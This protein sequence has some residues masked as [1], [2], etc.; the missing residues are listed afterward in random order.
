MR[1]IGKA[2]EFDV[3]L[4][5]R[6]YKTLEHPSTAKTML[7]IQYRFTAELG[8]FPSQEFYEGRL[9]SGLTDSRRIL[10]RLSEQTT[11]PWPTNSD[12]GI[13]IPTVFVNC[14]S[15]EDM[16]SMSKSNSGQVDLVKQIVGLLTTGDL[17]VTVLSPYTRQIQGLRHVVEVPCSTIDAFQGREADIIVFSTVRSNAEGD[18]GF[19]DDERRL[20]VL[21]TRARLGLVV[22]GDQKTLQNK[23]LWHRALSA[24]KDV[25][26]PPVANSS[27]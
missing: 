20:N 10:S 9:R 7:E 19:L 22:V 16:G 11:F 23:P 17:D 26:L 15:E 5:E 8:R 12:T 6:L 21:W 14:S 27:S 18:I 1:K 2:I 24:C 13:I 3:S 4:L 25:A